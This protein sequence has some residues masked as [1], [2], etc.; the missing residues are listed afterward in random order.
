[1][2]SMIER[3]SVDVWKHFILFYGRLTNSTVVGSIAFVLHNAAIV[4]RK[5]VFQLDSLP[6]LL[7]WRIF[8]TNNGAHEEFGRKKCLY[9][10]D[11]MMEINEQRGRESMKKW[12]R[13]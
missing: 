13:I 11:M 5:A 2:V 7:Y 10:L 9:S 4:V 6:L 3:N 1:M 8:A 12:H